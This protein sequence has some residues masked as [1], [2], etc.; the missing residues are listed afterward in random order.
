MRKID[1]A[2]L[3]SRVTF[4]HFLY[5]KRLCITVDNFFGYV[6]KNVC[7]WIISNIFLLFL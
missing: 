3:C 6:E 5:T 2:V 1:A 7:L 4:I